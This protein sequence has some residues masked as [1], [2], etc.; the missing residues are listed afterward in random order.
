MF[1]TMP[2]TPPSELPPI[3]I[4]ETVSYIKGE[5]EGE[6]KGRGKE[7]REGDRRVER[8]WKGEYLVRKWSNILRGDGRDVALVEMYYTEDIHDSISQI[9]CQIC[10]LLN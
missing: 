4:Y 9:I 2:T 1:H 10:C 8:E 3:D 6:G 5:R 7:G